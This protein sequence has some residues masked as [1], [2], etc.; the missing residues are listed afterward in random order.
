MRRRRSTDGRWESKFARFVSSYSVELLAARLRVNPSAIY[1]WLDGST[2]PHPTHAQ[3]IQRLAK[4]RRV[5][6][7]LEEIYKRTRK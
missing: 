4:R 1:H 3:A 2:S 7:S 5:A 6:L